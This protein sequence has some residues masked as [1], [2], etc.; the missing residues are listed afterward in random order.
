MKASV[1]SYGLSRSRSSSWPPYCYHIIASWTIQ[2]RELPLIHLRPND[3]LRCFRNPL[4]VYTYQE[5]DLWESSSDWKFNLS[6]LKSINSSQRPT[7]IYS[8]IRLKYLGKN[9]S[10][11][12][13][14]IYLLSI[15]LT[16]WKKKW[17]QK[18]YNNIDLEIKTHTYDLD[19]P[20]LKFIRWRTCLNA[21]QV[22][23]TQNLRPGDSNHVHNTLKS[24]L[25]KYGCINSHTLSTFGRQHSKI[26]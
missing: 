26:H 23:Y 21:L 7:S 13:T 14:Y 20:K 16:Q 25:Q 22:S 10:L 18:S 6:Y 24:G 9:L 1:L 15:N 2:V 4:K 19:V 12:W 8:L 11:D 5:I 3:F 17:L